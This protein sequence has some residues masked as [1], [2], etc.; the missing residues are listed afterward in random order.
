M[1]YSQIQNNMLLRLVNKK[2][3]TLFTVPIFLIIFLFRGYTLFGS[4][5]SS[6][7]ANHCSFINPS[8]CSVQVSLELLFFISKIKSQKVTARVCLRSWKYKLTIADRCSLQTT[9][10]ALHCYKEPSQGSLS[11]G[12]WFL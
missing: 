1:R 11:L 2:L 10:L 4:D 12:Y 5:R 3:Y 7:N 8:V 6:T 9:E